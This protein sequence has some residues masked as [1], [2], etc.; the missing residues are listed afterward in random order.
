MSR[1]IDRTRIEYGHEYRSD[2]I[3]KKKFLL[4]N[5][6]GPFRFQ[7]SFV[8]C[9]LVYMIHEYMAVIIGHRSIPGLHIYDLIDHQGCTIPL[10]ELQRQ[11][12]ALYDVIT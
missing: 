7:N 6:F 2:S 11:S 8:N 1:W 4:C 12:V 5:K 3:R 10:K 9:K